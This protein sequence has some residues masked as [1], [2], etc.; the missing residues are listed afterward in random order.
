MVRAVTV[1]AVLTIVVL[2]VYKVVVAREVE[3]VEM[4]HSHLQLLE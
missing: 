1:A 2:M 3:V 4:L